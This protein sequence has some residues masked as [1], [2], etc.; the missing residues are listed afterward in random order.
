MDAQHQIQVKPVTQYRLSYS[1]GFN[2]TLSSQSPTGDGYYDADSSTTATSSYIGDTVPNQQRQALTG[3]TLDS[4]ATTV[5][6]NETGTFTTSPIVF[7]TYHTLVFDSVKQYFVAFSFTDASGSKHVVPTS[8]AIDQQNG[9]VEDV[10]G[11]TAWVDNGTA[12]T[13]ASLTWE[14]VDVKPLGSTSHQVNAPEN[15]TIMSRVYPASLKVV[16][17]LG[18]G[19]QGAEVAAKLANGTTVTKATNSS[20]VVGFGLIPI[21]T[22]GAAISNLGVSTSTSADASV[23]SESTATVDVS[24]PVVGIVI[25]I[26]AALGVSA[27]LVRRRGRSGQALSSTG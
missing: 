22:Y 2:V 15:V 4:Q 7:D 8:L 10:P 1:G 26:V 18:L 19:V 16:D 13:V 24:V 5:P 23:R 14:G 17:L 3:Y 9:G 20:G 12:F 6:R 27:F 11:F 25:L 21:G